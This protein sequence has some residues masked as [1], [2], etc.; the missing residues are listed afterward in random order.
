LISKREF[1]RFSK[2]PV[3]APIGTNQSIF[4]HMIL[5]MDQH[6][7]Q[8]KGRHQRSTH[9]ALS[10]APCTD[11]QNNLADKARKPGIP[12]WKFGEGDV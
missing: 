1:W 5:P 12:V 7:R 2:L 8:Q 6:P 9:D 4:S 10:R 11:I 3:P